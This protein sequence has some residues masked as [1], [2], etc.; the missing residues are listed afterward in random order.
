MSDV[1]EVA[2]DQKQ[3]PWS[4]AG[5]TLLVIFLS[6]LVLFN[7]GVLL[8]GV[9]WLCSQP[10]SDSTF[11]LQPIIVDIAFWGSILWL[12]AMAVLVV[13]HIRQLT[14]PYRRK[15]VWK[16]LF[17]LGIGILGF[18]MLPFRID[19]DAAERAAFPAISNSAQSI[20]EALEKFKKDN[21]TYPSTLIELVPTYLR[22]VPSPGILGANSYGYEKRAGTYELF[23]RVGIE[24]RFFYIPEEADRQ[25]MLQNSSFSRQANNWIYLDT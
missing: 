1:G 21:G 16:T 4:A 3:R 24:D 23:V 5:T 2:S 25:T 15:T 22:Q 10:Q 17:P 19:F 8:R 9:R 7:P 20:V 6:I 18:F 14:Q 12:M 11:N 13:M